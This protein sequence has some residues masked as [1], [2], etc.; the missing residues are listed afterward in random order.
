MDSRTRKHSPDSIPLAI[1]R[2]GDGAPGVLLLHGFGDCAAIWAPVAER[3]SSRAQVVAP[4]LRGHGDSGWDS[5]GRY[6]IQDQVAAVLALI[7]ELEM[8]RFLLVG[9]SMGAEIA[10][11][12]AALR[13]FAVKALV[14]VEGAA[15]LDAAARRH[16]LEQFAQQPWS[17]RSLD[18]F[19]RAMASMLPLANPAAV[20]AYARHALRRKPDGWYELKCDPVLR[21]GIP[22]SAGARTKSALAQIQC[23][24]LLARGAISAMLSKANALRL[25]QEMKQCRLATIAMSGHAVLLENPEALLAAIEPCAG[26]AA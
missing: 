17:Y 4:D 15:D 22:P 16:L 13:P 14:L 26:A 18:E 11:H 24:T 19:E 7:D 23:P 21:A 1:R 3:L 25:C 12:V 6:A 20:K 2:W 5:L 10:A 9:H 8:G